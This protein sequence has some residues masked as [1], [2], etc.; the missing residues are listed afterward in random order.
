V[1]RW[2]HHTLWNVV[3]GT[4]GQK[5]PPTYL[6]TYLPRY[7]LTSQKES[8]QTRRKAGNRPIPSSH[9]QT[10][11]SHLIRTKRAD[12]SQKKPPLPNLADDHR[13]QATRPKSN[14]HAFANRS[15]IALHN[16]RSFPN[17]HPVPIANSP[18]TP[19]QVRHSSSAFGPHRL[20][21]SVH[22]VL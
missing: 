8:S 4:L 2:P 7:R 18:T 3:Y 11:P 1:K 20:A 6:P 22:S 15:G 13:K 10:R 5:P 21:H 9:P 12:G 14:P 19:D 16:C 17:P